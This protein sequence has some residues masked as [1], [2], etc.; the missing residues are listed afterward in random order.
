MNEPEL[1]SRGAASAQSRADGSG[2]RAGRNAAAPFF[3][4]PAERN[5]PLT[6][7]TGMRHVRDLWAKASS[8]DEALKYGLHGLRVLGYTLAKRGAGETLAVAQGGWR[9]DTHERYERF[10]YP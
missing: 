5:H 1:G 2:G 9:S 3:V 7:Q 10:L 8:E 4:A 6:Y